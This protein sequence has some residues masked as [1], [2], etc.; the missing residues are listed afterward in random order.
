M[1]VERQVGHEAFQ[2]RILVL[3]LPEPPKLAHAQMRVLL[4][5]DV[6]RRLA[7]AELAAMSAVAV[8]CSTWRNAYAI[9]SS[10]NFDFFIGP[11]SSYRVTDR[12]RYH[13]FRSTSNLPNYSGMRSI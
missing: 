9:C 10:L 6:E 11:S 13:A 2:P 7:H 5:P 3:E 1:L 8:P 12:Q 4:L